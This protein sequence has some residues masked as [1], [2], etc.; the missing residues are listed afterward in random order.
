MKT[1][2]LKKGG[3]KM[4][5]ST[6]K[7]NK[8]KK[9][10][11]S[12]MKFGTNLNTSV[13]QNL[14][15]QKANMRQGYEK[16]QKITADPVM[17]LNQMN[18]FLQTLKKY[19]ESSTKFKQEQAD[20]IAAFIMAETA[21]TLRDIGTP[22]NIDPEDV[23]DRFEYIEELQEIV[24]NLLKE[25]KKYEQLKLDMATLAISIHEAIREA[26]ESFKPENF[27]KQKP[28][29]TK[30]NIKQSVKKRNNNNN[31]NNKGE[32][33]NNLGNLMNLFGKVGI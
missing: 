1:R 25:N 23:E 18:N 11:V 12:Q 6:K 4:K 7:H 29:K 13:K 2:R 33:K 32:N 30:E 28:V 8:P 16:K 10:L 5:P 17:Y 24:E 19:N 22:I 9:L 3:A 15:K 21:D 27:R 20:Q 14:Q 31:N 26:R